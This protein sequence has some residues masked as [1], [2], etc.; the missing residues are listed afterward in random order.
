M[1]PPWQIQFA[2]FAGCGNPAF[3]IGNDDVGA[4]ARPLRQ[5]II[6]DT[7]NRNVLLHKFRMH[8]SRVICNPWNPVTL[9][10]LTAA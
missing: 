4:R 1:P 3:V 2:G 6:S 8:G 5:R 10:R 7:E 9:E